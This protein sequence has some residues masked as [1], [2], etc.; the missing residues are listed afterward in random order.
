[1]RS[2]RLL[3]FAKTPLRGQVK[4]RLNQELGIDGALAVHTSLIEFAWQEFGRQQR[5]RT[6][7]WVSHP[8]AE[9]YFKDLCGADN[10]HQQVGHDLG[11]RMQHAAE[12]ALKTSDSVVIV[13]ADCPSVDTAYVQQ[14]LSALA[15]PDVDVVLGP[16][17]DG[18]YVL[19]ALKEPVPGCLFQDIDWGS[20]RVLAQTRLALRKNGVRWRELSPRWDVD[21]PAD[22]QRYRQL[23]RSR[24]HAEVGLQ[25]D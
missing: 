20:D 22:V 8:G 14:A 25:I 3:I 18:G 23:L 21:R 5:L 17:E 1:M 11:A 10:V 9:N 24:S 12:T 4:T 6:E 7:M 15:A 16:A 19:V 13:G 2:A